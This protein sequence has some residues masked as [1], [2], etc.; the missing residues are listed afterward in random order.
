MRIKNKEKMISMDSLTSNSF[1]KKD[2]NLPMARFSACNQLDPQSPCF[3]ELLDSMIIQPLRALDFWQLQV[4]G[5][6][7]V[8]GV[9]SL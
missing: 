2:F 9:P 1:L 3:C 8:I 6:I 4:S 7:C 5:I